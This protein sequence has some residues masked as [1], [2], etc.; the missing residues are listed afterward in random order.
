MDLT[1]PPFDDVR[2]RYALAMSIDRQEII[3][4]TDGGC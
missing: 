4:A 3:D 2:I 1:K